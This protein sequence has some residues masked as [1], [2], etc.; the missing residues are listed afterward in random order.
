QSTDTPYSIYLEYLRKNIRHQLTRISHF[1][2]FNR[3]ISIHGFHRRVR[4]PSLPA[5]EDFVI[6]YIDIHAFRCTE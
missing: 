5:A 4:S 6:T 3:L 2:L 1:I